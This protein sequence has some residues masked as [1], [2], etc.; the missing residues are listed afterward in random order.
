M[1]RPHPYRPPRRR[2][3][4]AGKQPDGLPP[5]AGTACRGDRVRHPP[6]GRW[7]ADGDPR[8]DAGSYHAGQRPGGGAHGGGTCRP[9]SAGSTGGR[10]A[11]PGRLGCLW[12]RPTGRRLRVEVKTDAAHRPYPGLLEAALAVLAGA[13]MLGRSVVIAFDPATAA[14]AAAVG[15]WPAQCGRCPAAPCP[16]LG[17]AGVVAE[18]RRIGVPE[19][20][21]ALREATPALQAAV[22]RR[23]YASASGARIGGKRSTAPWPL[24]W[25]RWP[26]TI[27]LSLL[28]LRRQPQLTAAAGT[29][30]PGRQP[31]ARQ[32]RQLATGQARSLA[33]GR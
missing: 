25:M 1:T 18:A 9:A 14:Q 13:G 30:R 33:S 20:D 6:L 27:H 28:R 23:G 8:S 19:V 5:G 22:R 29:G 17:P 15:G 3:V 26:P 16:P 31:P 4:V 12:S 7:R 32:R 2:P 10:G 24:G 11:D 21:C